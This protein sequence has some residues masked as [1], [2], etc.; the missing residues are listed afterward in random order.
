ME[1]T[2]S[3]SVLEEHL[4]VENMWADRSRTIAEYSSANYAV[5][6]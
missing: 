1:C 3:K 2:G 5:A 4:L 6:A